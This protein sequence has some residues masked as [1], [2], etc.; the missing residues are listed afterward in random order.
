MTLWASVSETDI[1]ITA[2]RNDK[3]KVT[4]LPPRASPSFQP[5]AIRKSTCATFALSRAEYVLQVRADIAA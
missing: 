3:G 5:L 4:P 1:L 2:A